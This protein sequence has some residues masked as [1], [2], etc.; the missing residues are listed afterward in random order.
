LL[1]ETVGTLAI[2]SLHDMGGVL[3]LARDTILSIFRGRFHWKEVFSQMVRIGVESLPASMVAAAFIGMVFS[4]QIASEFVRFGAG[5]MV[6]AVMAIAVS[7]ELAPVLTAV[8]ISGR[9]GAAIA[10]EIGTMSVTEQ[11]D[12]MYAMGSNPV[13]HLVVPRFFAL[14]TMLPILTLFADFIGFIGGYLVAVYLV[15]INPIGY[16]DTAAS[17]VDFSDITG[18]LIKAI[19]LGMIIALV[20]C[21]RGLRAHGGARG[22]GEATTHAVVQ[23]LILIF[24]TNYFLSIILFKR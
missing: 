3:L 24:V 8:I 5:Q 13:K 18:G 19:F 20:G 16:V 11:I 9:V 4:V 1:F 14:T 7:R 15:G 12:A 17:Y 22:V 21:Y 6:G 2:Q 23:S 10:A